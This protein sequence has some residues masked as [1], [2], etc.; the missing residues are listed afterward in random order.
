MPRME[1]DGLDDLIRDLQAAA[2]IPDSVMSDM[3][4]SEA[5]IIV[6]AQKGKINSLGLVDSGQLLESIRIDG[7]MKKDASGRY[8]D[9]YPQGTRKNGVRNAEVGFIHEY[10]APGR[11]ISAKNWMKQA[12][13]GA[14]DEA[15]DAAAEV[16]DNF[17]KSKNL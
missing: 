17:L 9:V 2:E 1:I 4:K 14:A 3:L 6:D 16:Y 10:G 8:V 13:E 12:N 11:H 5:D 7:S 15:N